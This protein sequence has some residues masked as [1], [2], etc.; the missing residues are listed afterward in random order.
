[1]PAGPA[2]GAA[3]Q[4]LVKEASGSS[5]TH[6]LWDQTL[7]AKI[8]DDVKLMQDAQ[9]QMAST[10]EEDDEWVRGHGGYPGA[11]TE[12]DPIDLTQSRD[13]KKRRID[14]L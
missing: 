8:D 4:E 12:D 1:M 13:M 6:L 9:D 3:I 5:W 10:D 2:R 14:E 11:G 7:D